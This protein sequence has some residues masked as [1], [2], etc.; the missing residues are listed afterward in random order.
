LYNILKKN[1]NIFLFYPATITMQKIEEAFDFAQNMT[2]YSQEFKSFVRAY[3]CFWIY[4]RSLLCSE[5][6]KKKVELLEWIRENRITTLESNPKKILSCWS[7]IQRYI[8]V[9]HIVTL[10]PLFSICPESMVYIVK[11]ITKKKMEPYA[12]KLAEKKLW[13]L[14]HEM[15]HCFK[16]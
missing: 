7:T 15:F 14:D 2:K 10:F 3:Y 16:L 4:K 8:M 5:N 6:D 9:G 12:K 13:V 1:E 11:K